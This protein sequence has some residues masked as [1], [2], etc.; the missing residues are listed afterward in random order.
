[1]RQMRYLTF[2]FVVLFIQPGPPSWAQDSTL[3]LKSGSVRFAVIGDM[4]TGDAPQY[5]IAQRMLEFHQK[6]P[7]TFAI[8]LG[9]NIYGG[10]SPADLKKKFEIPYQP[11]LDA[12][13][14]FYA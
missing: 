7:F 10:K 12:G 14:Q 6:F 3:P 4:G 13:V 8:M 5:Q 9:D 11:L 1:M 2:L